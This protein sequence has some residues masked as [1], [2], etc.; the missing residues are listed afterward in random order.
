MA[1]IDIRLTLLQVFIPFTVGPTPVKFYRFIVVF[2][3]WKIHKKSYTHS[4]TNDYQK[5]VETYTRIRPIH[6]SNES[7]LKIYFLI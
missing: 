1:N 2:N 4:K 7:S 5:I 3:G 6:I